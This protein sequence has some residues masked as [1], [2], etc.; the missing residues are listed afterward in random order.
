M[1][2][3]SR[4][5]VVLS[6]YGAITPLGSTLEE[7]A[8]ALYEGCSGIR[9][10]E[11][12]DTTCFL[13][14]WAGVPEAGNA[15]IRWP[16]PVED[17]MYR[18]GEIFYAENATANLLTRIDPL[19]IYPAERLGCVLGVD[20][21]AY[22][23]QRLI[24]FLKENGSKIGKD[25]KSFFDEAINYYRLSEIIDIDVTAVLREIHQKIPFQ[26]YTRCHLGLCSASLQAL[27][28]ARSAILRG[29]IDAAIVGGVSG[30]VTQSNL[31]RL[32][33]LSAVCTDPELEAGARSRP[34]DARRSGFVPAEGAVL[35]LM[36]KESE[37]RKRGHVPLVRLL[38]YGSSQSAEHII[39]PHTQE[40]ETTLCMQR[41]LHDAGVSPSEISNINAHGTS[42]KLNDL[43]ESSA[44]ARLF[45]KALPQVTA[46]K[47]LHGHM[48]A[49]AAAMEVLGIAASFENDFLPAIAN[50]D[51]V[52]PEIKVPLVRETAPGRVGKVLKNSLGMGGLAA[53]LI[54]EN[55]RLEQ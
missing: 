1:A 40:L 43:H 25:W 50:L 49:A 31:A 14:K 19:S 41:A 20:E 26:G 45:D 30:K 28:M 24:P 54:L 48:I 52:D 17:Q 23:S 18:P 12:F 21:P 42:T 11:K 51:T 10:I 38:G 22:D 27:G 2:H 33:S 46:T 53:T 9:S 6:A 47:S 8:T 3:S 5:P 15:A 16:R 39:A 29:S 37:A 36:E 13:T 7:I 44:I 55:P 34:F 32:E 4:E 35:F